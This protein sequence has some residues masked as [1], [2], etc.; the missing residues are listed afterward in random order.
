MILPFSPLCSCSMHPTPVLRHPIPG[1]RLLVWEES[2]DHCSLTSAL[3]TTPG[4]E[5][6]LASKGWRS[7]NS[8]EILLAPESGA[9]VNLCNGG[10]LGE[11]LVLMRSSNQLGEL[12]VLELF[13]GSGDSDDILF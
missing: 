5:G 9:F 12:A 11:L 4:L 1:K 3:S 13:L 6:L 2:A 10:G 8:D 7:R